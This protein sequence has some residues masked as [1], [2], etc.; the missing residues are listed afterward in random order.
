[1]NLIPNVKI[2]EIK[3]GVLEKSAISFNEEGLDIR[4][5]KALKKLPCEQ[6]G[7]T[8]EICVDTACAET[9][10][11][12]PVAASEGYEL[13]IGEDYYSKVLGVFLCF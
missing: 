13:Q 4:L 5:V 11:V 3:N 9:A 12:L 8:V 10:G 7:T 6:N 2:L 1:M